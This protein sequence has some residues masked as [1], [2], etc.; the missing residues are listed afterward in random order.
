MLCEAF[1]WLT[2]SAKL[3][4]TGREHGGPY[5]QPELYRGSCARTMFDRPGAQDGTVTILVPEG[6]V[7]E[8]TLNAFVRI[9]SIH[10]RTGQIEAEYLGVVASGRFAEP[11]ALSATAPTL[12]VAAV[13]GAVLTPKYHG[14]AHVHMCRSSPSVSTGYFFRPSGG[15]ART[16]RSFSWVGR[17]SHTYWVLMCPPLIARS[18]SE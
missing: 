9:P 13:H 17:T 12:V 5:E 1:M 4:Q 10:P 3:E 18:V 8:L 7:A 2:I 16:A 15:L 6:S 14:I 11:D